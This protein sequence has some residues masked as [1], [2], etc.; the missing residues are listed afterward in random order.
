MGCT[1]KS[2]HTYA[3]TVLN[4]HNCEGAT[5]TSTGTHL[6]RW[7]G[8]HLGTLLGTHLGTHLS[9][10]LGTHLGTNFWRWLG[11]WLGQAQGAEKIQV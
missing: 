6:W 9:T 7:L 2:L 4:A 11:R 10:L 3:R 8:T 5:T 1:H